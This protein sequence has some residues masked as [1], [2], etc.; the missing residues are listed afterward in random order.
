LEL[1]FTSQ[2]IFEEKSDICVVKQI[3]TKCSV[4]EVEKSKILVLPVEKPAVILGNGCLSNISAVGYLLYI[5][6]FHLRHIQ[7]N[8]AR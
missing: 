2:L 3:M 1:R 8:S 5:A 4:N 7:V 6:K